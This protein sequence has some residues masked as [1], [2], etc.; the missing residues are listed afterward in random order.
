M[1]YY[2]ASGIILIPG[3]LFAL[4][5]SFKV[6]STYAKYSKVYGR[7]GETA[8]VVARNMLNDANLYDVAVIRTGG[9]LT[10]HFDPRSK[11]LALSDSVYNSTSVAAI[12]IAAH[13]VGHAI[14]HKQEYVPL[15]I[16]SALVPVVNISSR[17][18]WPI[19]FLGFIFSFLIELPGFGE[20]F[21]IAGLVL[22]GGAF[23]FSLVTLPVEFNA[24]S[25][26]YRTILDNRILDREEAAL[27][28]KVLNAAALTY[29]ASMLVALLNLVRF[30]M[31]FARRR[32]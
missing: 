4:Y 9:H 21:L 18:L 26:A 29:V 10:D 2:Y 27:S 3:I 5:A 32:R 17:V 7:R 13:E 23:L 14:Q 15:K 22:F 16:R 1:W 20:V 11:T 30:L 19:V 24:S 31:V 6:N 28:K 8:A 25:R 12:G